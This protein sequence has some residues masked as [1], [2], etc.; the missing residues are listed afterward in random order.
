METTKDI[1]PSSQ[2]RLRANAYFRECPSRTVLDLL[3]DKW[4]LLVI[5]ALSEGPVRFGELRRRIDGVT[6]KMLTQT[7]R[8]L[9]RD[10]LVVRKV[11]PTTP[12]SVEYSLTRLGKGSVEL[13]H[14]LRE[15]AER[16]VGQVLAAR[17][18]FD[19]QSVPA[20]AVGMQRGVVQRPVD[21][22]I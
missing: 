6:Q 7:L 12:P 10:G 5:C 20:A 16:H 13:M 17:E 14:H 19:R 21:R 11:Y 2:K 15:W 4:T 9:E 22:R 8:G 3:S 1:H 18:E